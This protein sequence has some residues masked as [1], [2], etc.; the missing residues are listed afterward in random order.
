L[1]GFYQKQKDHVVT[2]LLLVQQQ[3]EQQGKEKNIGARIRQHTSAY[4]RIRQ[5]TSGY[6]S[7]ATGALDTAPSQ[8]KK[9]EKKQEEKS[10]L[11]EGPCPRKRF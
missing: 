10:N 8:R 7:I 5:H 9:E 6:V 2:L 3:Q 4:V 1:R 11:A